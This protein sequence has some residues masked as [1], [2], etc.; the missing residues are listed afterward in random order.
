MFVLF[1]LFGAGIA[2]H[3]LGLV[4]MK[5]TTGIT[6]LISGSGTV[7]VSDALGIEANPTVPVAKAGTLTTH[8]TNTT[9]TLT[10]G[11]G[12]GIITGQRIDIYWV[13]G[14]CY[15]AIAG[16]VSG[17]TVPIASVAGGDNLPASATAVTVGI[18][19]VSPF[20]L[21]GDN[22]QAFAFTTNVTGYFAVVTNSAELLAVYLTAGNVY[23]WFAGDLATNPLAGVVPTKIWMSHAVTTAPQKGMAAAAVS[24]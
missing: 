12:H 17:N 16:T 22:I 19:V 15:G 8:T 9:G 4:S 13:G 14:S 21:T 11:A 10:M 6:G 1:C 5:C 20:N 18:P 2:L 24:H 7:S 3:L 23:K